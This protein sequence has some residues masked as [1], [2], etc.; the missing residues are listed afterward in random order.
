MS[1]KYA[2]A[3]IG[4]GPGGYVT[5]I[6]CAQLGLKTV[7][8]EKRKTLGGTCLNVG[9]IPSKALL[10]ITHK[11]HDA[12]HKFAD[13]GILAD[14][15]VVDVAKMQ[16]RKKSVV[17]D[18]TKGIDFLLKKNK[19]DRI[20]AT[21]T[22]NADKTIT[23]GDEIVVADTI[24]LAT[25]SMPT[26]IPGIKVDEQNIVTSTGALEFTEVPEHM[27]VIGGGVIGLEMGSIWGRLGTNITIVEYADTIIPQMDKDVIK[28][29]TTTLKKQKFKFKTKTKVT[30]VEKTDSGLSVQ[31]E[32]RDNGNT[33]CIT[34]DK[35]LVA[36]G[37]VPYT[38]GLGLDAVGVNVCTH[39]FIQVDKNFQTNIEGIFA[40]GDVIG[41]AMLA[42]KAEEEGGAV[43]EFLTG[44]TTVHVNH[45]NI[46]SVIYTHP[47]VAFTGLTEQQVKHSGIPYIVGQF[48]FM[49]NSRGRATGNTE[50]FVKVIA[51]KSTDKVLGVHIVGADAGTMIHEAVIIMEYS[52]TAED[53]FRCCHAHPTLNEALKEAALAVHKRAVHA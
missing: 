37:R 33:D 48:P 27:V 11:F 52:G 18:L 29:F 16:H 53:L 21:A 9:C 46:P 20:V 45:N 3:V 5:A 14:S 32:G 13:M 6:R 7:C 1:K 12:Q 43:A 17:A 25:G 41:G 42:H 40:I 50:G 39:G 23:A 44:K 8:I 30:G 26:Q 24:I 2:V 22:L 15:V 38:E 35:V 19:V 28:Q 49:A 31:V 34:C 4:G 10:D 47:E 36:V 51:E